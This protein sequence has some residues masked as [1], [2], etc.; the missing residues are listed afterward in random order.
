MIRF[1]VLLLGTTLAFTACGTFQ[2]KEIE[3]GQYW[4]RISASDAAYQ[5]GPKAQQML[6]RDIGRC[7]TELR[8]LERSGQIKDAIPTDRSGRVLNPDEMEMADHDTPTHEGALLM[9][10]GDY[11]DFEGCML[12]KGWERTKHVPY[13]VYKTS[14][15]NYYNARHDYEPANDVSGSNNVTTRVT[16]RTHGV[17]G[18]LFNE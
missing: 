12:N 8:E 11:H 7:V 3:N 10:Q 4:Q 9:E 2:D 14:Q 13:D 16:G 6:N 15:D 1:S 17:Q 18:A 5:T